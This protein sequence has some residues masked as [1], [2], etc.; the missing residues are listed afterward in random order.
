MA[1]IFFSY[2]RS[3]SL[4][5]TKRIYQQFEKSFGVWR[6]LGAQRRNL[7]LDKD[8][9]MPKGDFRAQI[10]RFI[11]QSDHMLVVIGDTWLEEIQRRQTTEEKDF[12]L[13]EIESAF[14]H[15]VN[16]IPVLVH[17]ATM[18]SRDQLPDEIKQLATQHAHEIRDNHFDEDTK[19]LIAYTRPA[20]VF[21]VLNALV[22]LLVIIGL[23]VI[24]WT[25]LFTNNQPEIVT[26]QV[27]D[28]PTATDTISAED[29]L[30]TDAAQ[31]YATL[32]ALAPRNTP[33]SETVQEALHRAE[34]FSGTNRDWLPFVY[35]F[36]DDPS[37]SEMMLVPVGRFE[38]GST[39]EDINFAFEMC[40][41]ASDDGA[42]CRR[43]WFENEAPNGDNTQIFTEPFWID[44]TEVTRAQYQQCVLA[45]SCSE[46]SES[47]FSVNNDQPI[48]R[49]SW[50][51]ADA[52][53]TWRGV[54]LSTEAEW[55]YAARGTDNLLFPW[56]NNFEASFSNH[57]DGNCGV[58][59]W[60][61]DYE[62]VNEENDD[63]YA[64]TA[65]VR[66]YPDGASWVGA[67]NM[68]GNVWEWTNS[69]YEDYPYDATDGREANTGTRSD[70]TR[71]LRGGS[72]DHA[73]FNL[74][75]AVRAQLTPNNV[76][77]ENYGIR[78]ARSDDG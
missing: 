10:Q 1:R 34:S 70:L 5:T 38:M 67:F 26:T 31:A 76:S 6:Y 15:R 29:A 41:N 43:S 71:V 8:N 39:E 72:F 3:D 73:A 78:C 32:T 60:S 12:V 2:R 50:F 48:N 42:M 30:A 36:S 54:R 58:E 56:G 16:I 62:Y 53:C 37:N 7:F 75:S 74:R 9:I 18:P 17:G 51:Q 35:I 57:C 14:M 68:S 63:S 23:G 59:S 55:E 27:A 47:E 33:T 64:I 65:P 11:M 13:I 25:G 21:N 19:Q 22:I 52:Y 4:D 61:E 49:V 69:I 24:T 45:G 44:R 28:N 77:F 40:Q 46:T 66:S 20:I